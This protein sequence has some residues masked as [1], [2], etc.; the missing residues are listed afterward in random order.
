MNWEG[1]LT[2]LG[3]AGFAGFV[4][5]FAVKKLI[6]LFLMFVGLYLLS[7]LWLQS[8]GIIDINWEQFWVLFK[9]L[10]HG[11]DAFVK[12]ALKTVVFSSAFA[13]GFF[14]GFKAG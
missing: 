11:V 14:L 2:D 13:G 6:N 12:G 10:F 5:G 9:S 7:L 4:V 1:L 3:Y 8:K